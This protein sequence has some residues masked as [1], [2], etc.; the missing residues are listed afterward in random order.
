M[1]RVNN[2]LRD[3]LDESSP[4]LPRGPYGV[5]SW[6]NDRKTVARVKE[7]YPPSSVIRPY[8]EEG[9]QTFLGA[10][11]QIKQEMMLGTEKNIYVE[12]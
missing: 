3:W 1:N 6:I 5:D 7:L 4:R 12:R 10:M 11:A 9:R 8:V 2:N